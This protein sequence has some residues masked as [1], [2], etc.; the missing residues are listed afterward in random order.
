MSRAKL[1]LVEKADDCRRIKYL[2]GSMNL[3]R[4]N[5]E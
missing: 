4:F 2:A 1:K 5:D 3:W